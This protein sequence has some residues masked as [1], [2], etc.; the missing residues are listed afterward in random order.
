MENREQ[1]GG[2][3]GEGVG[4]GVEWEVGAL[5]CKPLWMNNKVLLNSTENCIQYLMIS[6]NGKEDFK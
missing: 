2:C 1:I 4:G 3:C 6:H 5:K